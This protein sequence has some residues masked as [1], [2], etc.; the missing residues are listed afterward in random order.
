MINT[1]EAD[2]KALQVDTWVSPIKISRSKSYRILRPQLEL[3]PFFQHYLRH[4]RTKATRRTS[5][6][7]IRQRVPQ[8]PLP[9]V[10]VC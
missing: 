3:K 7:L 8:I 6:L 1:L 5:S 9:A 4:L 10:K 2:V